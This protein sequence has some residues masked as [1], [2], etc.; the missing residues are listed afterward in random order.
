MEMTVT[1][2]GGKRVDARVGD[3]TIRTD[4]PASAGGQGSA[5]EPFTLF[6]A[7]LATCAG[8]YVLGYCQ[9]RGI[10]IDGVRLVQR[11][12][13]D[14]KTGLLTTVELEIGLPP[15]FPE[16]HRAPIARAAAACKVKKTLAAPPEVR[17]SVTLPGDGLRASG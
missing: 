11:S 12:E 4:Q 2:P 6:Q 9:A 15:G 7:S 5:P 3:F 16:E 8:I 1:F 17:V 13:K 14:A 10:P